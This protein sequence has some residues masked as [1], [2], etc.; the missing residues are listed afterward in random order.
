MLLRLAA[1]ETDAPHAT[2]CCARKAL[3]ELLSSWQGLRMSWRAWKAALPS[4]RLA[5]D[6]AQALAAECLAL[7]SELPH[8]TPPKQAAEEILALAVPCCSSQARATKE[9]AVVALQSLQTR[10]RE[11]GKAAK[12]WGRSRVSR[13]WSWF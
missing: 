2:R 5:T 13:S 10:L 4:G 6:Q 3:R 7:L 12:K 11:D 8:N 9:A 1:N